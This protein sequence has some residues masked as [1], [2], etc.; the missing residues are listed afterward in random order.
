MAEP[1][2]SI[3]VLTDT[4]CDLPPSCY[5]KYPIFCLPLR[6]SCGDKMYRD[7][8]D[9][10][11]EDI[12]E[13]QK[14]EN[15]KTCAPS[16]E[17]IA[18]AFDTIHDRGY[19]QVIVMPIASALSEGTTNLLRLMAQE[20]TDLDIAVFN[21][22]S[23]SIGVGIL[24]LQAAQYAARGLPF[25]VVKKLVEQL[26]KDT[27]VFFCL[28]TLEYL[29][30]GGRIG[31][32]T[33][34]AGTLLQIKPIL[35]FDKTGMTY[36]PAKVRGRKAVAPWLIQ[37]ISEMVE[38]EK[39]RNGGR[40]RFNLVVCDGNVPQEGDEL[41]AALTA[42][43]PGSEQVVRGRLSATLAVHLGPALL[44]AGIQFLRSEL[45]G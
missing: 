34:V 7:G 39:S 29:Q 12:Y 27:S 17:D 8:I 16:E 35:S 19:R 36:S 26:V 28:S 24:A 37:H 42:A 18:A 10:T 31:R 33:A 13:R 9:I 38:Q 20:R 5:E 15:F 1:A 25:H 44:G 30:R 45:P 40:V 41:Q 23:S 22:C 14:T 4:D 6:I 3:A 32:A 2:S 43:V 21:S 11:V